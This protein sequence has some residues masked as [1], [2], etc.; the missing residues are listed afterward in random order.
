MI[1]NQQRELRKHTIGASDAAAVLGIDPWRTPLE[2]YLEKVGIT[3]KPDTQFGTPM[4]WGNMLEDVVAKAYED[5]TGI[6][7]RQSCGTLRHKVHEFIVCHLDRKVSGKRKILE[8]KTAFSRDKWGEP[9]TDEVPLNYLVQ[10][11]HQMAVTGYDEAD[12]AVL[13]GG[14][15]FRCYTIARD[16]DIINR[17]IEVENKFWH[18]HVISEVP[19]E[20]SCKKDVQLLYTADNTKVI[21]AEQCIADAV[22]Q[23]AEVKLQSKE[24]DKQQGELENQITL[25]MKDATSLHYYGK[26]IVSW[27]ADKNGKRQLRIKV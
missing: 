14:S 1:T 10:V 15:E 6:K 3:E 4:Y 19:P 27:K 16:E 5:Y 20:P 26:E 9:G 24:L 11:Q 23:L 18:D 7:V 2:V 8:C 25:Y 13:I 12:I 17:I 21:D 22:H